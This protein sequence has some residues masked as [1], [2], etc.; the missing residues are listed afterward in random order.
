[1]AVLTDPAECGPVTLAFCQ[2]VQ[3]EAYDYPES[4][5]DAARLAPRRPRAGRRASSRAP[6]AL[7]RGAKRPLIVAGGG[8]LYSEADARRCATSP[9][10]RH[11]GRRDAGRQGRAALGPSAAIWARS[12][13]PA[14]RPPTRWPR[15]AD[16]VLAVGTR[17]QDFTTGSWALFQ[18]AGRRSIAAQRRSPSTPAS[19][20]RC[21]WSR[22]A[23]A[24]WRRSTTALGD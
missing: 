7:L 16:V 10:A 14:P 19:T 18:S 22:D 21:R 3:A 24:A 13:S 8:V 23:S 20:A 15:E 4:F 17:L 1:M 2:D 6:S 11:S 5:F 12:A 9:S